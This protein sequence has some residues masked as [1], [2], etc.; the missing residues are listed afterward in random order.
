MPSP[1]ILA[2]PSAQFHQDMPGSRPLWT[3][4]H[5]LAL[6]APQRRRSR[7]A[8]RCRSPSGCLA[9]KASGS[10]PGS[11]STHGPP[12]SR[13]NSTAAPPGAIELVP[14]ALFVRQPSR[15]G[16]RRSGDVETASDSLPRPRRRPAIRERERVSPISPNTCSSDP[17]ASNVAPLYDLIAAGYYKPAANSGTWAFG[18]P[19]GVGQRARR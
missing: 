9:G 3:S 4:R 15:P 1:L 12:A 11:S 2:A 18:R 19:G 5:W 10:P 14:E 7:G 13:T 17:S 8:G 6:P 16:R